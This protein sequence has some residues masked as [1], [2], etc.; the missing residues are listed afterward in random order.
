MVDQTSD[1]VLAHLLRRVADRPKL[2]AA[3]MEVEVDRDTLAALP[4]SAFAWPE[5]RAYP[6]HTA[7]QALLSRVY[8]EGVTGVPA[9]VDTALKQ[10]SDVYGLDESVFASTKTAAPVEEAA[11]AFLLPTHRRL[12][13]TEAAHVK[14]A[15]ETLRTEGARLSVTNRAHAAARLVKKAADHGVG[16]RVET[17]KMAG[18][19]VTDTAQL[20]DWVE[21]RM[22]AASPLHKQGYQKLAGTIKQLP[23]ELRDRTLQVKVAETLYELDELAGLTH[24]YGRTLPD[25]LNTVFNTTKAAGAGVT[26]AGRFVPMERLAFYDASFYSDALGPDIVREASDVSGQLDPAKLAAVLETLPVDMQRAL[27]AQMR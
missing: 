2:A 26:L 27:S 7:E 19:T 14:I 15:E 9:Y 5:K 13:V 12:R 18:M 21:A 20:S 3:V 25:P 11:D 4:D 23:A 22:A 6:I 10:A 17:L 1:P 8:R 16:L 24:H